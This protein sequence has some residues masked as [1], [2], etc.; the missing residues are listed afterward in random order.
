MT[1]TA[2]LKHKSQ[3]TYKSLETKCTPNSYFKPPIRAIQFHR[4]LVDEAC[5]KASM[6]FS[7]YDEI[8][9]DKEKCSQ[10]TVSFHFLHKLYGRLNR[11]QEEVFDKILTIFE[12]LEDIA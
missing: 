2:L 10:Y 1:K 9:H 3:K 6:G 11:N 4:E 12:N 7:F 5:T 8:A